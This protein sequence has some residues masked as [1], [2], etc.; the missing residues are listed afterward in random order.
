M[1]IRDFIERKKA[2]FFMARSHEGVNKQ[3]EVLLEELTRAETRRHEVEGIRNL[4][5]A[6]KSERDKTRELEGHTGGKFRERFKALRENV[7]RLDDRDQKRALSSP[8]ASAGPAGI[9]NL[10][11]SPM[12][13][14]GPFSTGG[15]AGRVPAVKI[16]K[17]KEKT[18]IIK[19]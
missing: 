12:R 11:D 4:Q 19:V 14:D 8:F 1:G 13:A 15:A 3:R 10:N 5:D 9:R 7:K 17:P 6:L 16:S 2:E 18:I